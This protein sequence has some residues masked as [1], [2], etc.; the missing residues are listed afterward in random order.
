MAERENL[1][2]NWTEDRSENRIEDQP[3]DRTEERALIKR[4]TCIQCPQGCSLEV[5][6]AF[7][8][9]L[10]REEGDPERGKNGEQ[11]RAMVEAGGEGGIA[12]SS[13]E[14]SSG[15]PELVIEGNRC[16]QGEE[17][18]RKEV[19]NPTRTLASTVATRFEECPRLP[20]RTRG[21]IP[22]AKVFLA[23]REINSL[24]VT[25]PTAPGEVVLEDLLGTGVDLIATGS[26][27]SRFGS[28]VDAGSIGSFFL[29][30]E[31]EA[32]V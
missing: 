29:P 2:E 31:K 8:P 23:M 30:P 16:R 15:T 7:S 10:Y 6:P 27:H 18:A 24:V 13:G 19:L 5:Y 25:R 9:E 11:E 1:T 4:L 32:E 28:E 26:T 17:Y 14:S 3:E 22:L 12:A 20:V 21:E